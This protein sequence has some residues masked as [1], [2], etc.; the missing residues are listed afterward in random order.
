MAELVKEGFL[1]VK[2]HSFLGSKYKRSYVRLFRGIPAI[3]GQSSRRKKQVPKTSTPT[4]Q[5]TESELSG[6][7]HTIPLE[8]MWEVVEK[9]SKNSKRWAFELYYDG[10]VIATFA[11]ASVIE[12]EDWLRCFSS[13]KT[14]SGHSHG[15]YD[16]YRVMVKRSDGAAELGIS[17]DYTLTICHKGLVLKTTTGQEVQ[18]WNHQHIKKLVKSSRSP[19]TLYLEV[20]RDKNG[21]VLSFEFGMNDHSLS[22]L[23]K[24]WQSFI[25]DQYDQDKLQKV[26]EMMSEPDT[27][28]LPELHENQ[29]PKRSNSVLSEQPESSTTN[30][31]L[32]RQPSFQFQRRYPPSLPVVPDRSR[33]SLIHMDFKMNSKEPPDANLWREERGSGGGVEHSELGVSGSSNALFV[34]NG[35]L[36]DLDQTIPPVLPLRE[37]ERM[38]SS[39]DTPTNTP[40]TLAPTSLSSSDRSH[41]QTIPN[42]VSGVTEQSGVHTYLPILPSTGGS[43][44]MEATSNKDVIQDSRHR[45]LILPEATFTHSHEHKRLAFKSRTRGSLDEDPTASVPTEPGHKGAGQ[46]VPSHRQHHAPQQQMYHPTDKQDFPILEL[47]S[48]P[49]SR[50]VTEM[51]AVSSS[52]ATQTSIARSEVSNPT[53]ATTHVHTLSNS[54]ENTES[55]SNSLHPRPEEFPEVDERPPLPPRDEENPYGNV[56]PNKEYYNIFREPLPEPEL[57]PPLPPKPEGLFDKPPKPSPI[58][59]ESKHPRCT[60]KKSSL[61]KIQRTQSSDVKSPLVRKT[62]VASGVEVADSVPVNPPLPVPPALQNQPAITEFTGLTAQKDMNCRN[63]VTPTSSVTLSVASDSGSLHE[64]S[65]EQPS[66]PPPDTTPTGPVDE[67]P[68]GAFMVSGPLALDPPIGQPLET[69]HGSDNQLGLQQT[70]F[71]D[72]HSGFNSSLSSEFQPNFSSGM[73]SDSSKGSDE[74]MEAL[75]QIQERMD[76]FRL[77]FPSD[78]ETTSSESTASATQ[79]LPPLSQAMMPPSLTTLSQPLATPPQPLTTLSQALATPPQPLTTLPQPLTTPSQQSATPQPLATSLDQL[80]SMT[81]QQQQMSSELQHL[82]SQH[83]QILAMQNFYRQQQQQQQQQHQQLQQLLQQQQQ[84]EGQFPHMGSPFS[85][86]ILGHSA[87]LAMQ[88][89]ALSLPLQSMMSNFSQLPAYQLGSHLPGGYFNTLP[90]FPMLQ[91]QSPSPLPFQYPNLPNGDSFS[92]FSQ[93]AGPQAKS[94][95]I[96]AKGMTKPSNIS[97]VNTNTHSNVDN[98]TPMLPSMGAMSVGSTSDVSDIS[99]SLFTG[100]VRTVTSGPDLSQHDIAAGGGP[101]VDTALQPS[102]GGYLNST[103]HLRP[104]ATSATTSTGSL[105]TK[106]GRVS[107]APPL[108]ESTAVVKTAPLNQVTPT[109]TGWTPPLNQT[110]STPA[111]VQEVRSQTTPTSAVSVVSTSQT[112]PDSSAGALTRSRSP[113]TSGASQ[114]ALSDVP[115]STTTVVDS[116]HLSQAAVT[117]AEMESQLNWEEPEPY[118]EPAELDGGHTH[119]AVSG[120]GKKGTRPHTTVRRVVEGPKA[121]LPLS[122]KSKAATSSTTHTSTT[123]TTDGRQILQEMQVR[124]QSFD[125]QNSLNGTRSPHSSGRRRKSSMGSGGGGDN[126]GVSHCG[127]VHKTGTKSPRGSGHR[128]KTSPTGEGQMQPVRASPPPVPARSG[129]S[130]R[131]DD[132]TSSPSRRTQQE[133]MCLDSSLP[134]SLVAS[135]KRQQG[136]VDFSNGIINELARRISPTHPSTVQATQIKAHLH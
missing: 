70:P 94:S 105:P 4:I 77:C 30:Q 85:N 43:T 11:C 25:L 82:Q 37:Q 1:E 19:D 9:Q 78:L 106:A 67:I 63:D 72:F 42:Q 90:T 26:L 120:M 16:T 36:L 40:T 125:R 130:L 97:A 54:K 20:M 55:V 73:N 17:G 88:P 84:L 39:S 56:Q 69:I 104:P 8:K 128:R 52:V 58:S 75:R 65:L 5:I 38:R 76:M 92:S 46:P 60:C 116:S 33:N 80:Y 127:D 81:M 74:D 95:N 114:L 121:S 98:T 23:Q 103:T 108:V 45:S 49:Y 10:N 24:E 91:G 133:D 118:L 27:H 6:D 12:R 28:S 44:V 110:T 64:Y 119:M 134:K 99:T 135:R 87:G 15:P 34:A 129:I 132:P 113:P 79:L 71:S 31:E 7:V 107:T 66:S 126:H 111:L 18:E 3:Q 112:V 50:K 123:P 93:S 96:S 2:Q 35:D 102:L 61:D 68:P 48:P 131:Q 32:P 47:S 57:P 101:S 29:P 41:L 21:R 117:D 83:E 62:S 124:L 89:S 59:A 136:G 100:N 14:P 86:Q 22:K 13:L 115:T 53:T 51:S 109:S 122:I